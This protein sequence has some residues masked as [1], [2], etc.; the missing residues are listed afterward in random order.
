MVLKDYDEVIDMSSEEIRLEML[1]MWHEVDFNILT[2]EESDKVDAQLKLYRDV[3]R[4]RH[5]QYR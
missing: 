1:Q 5:Y 2:K 4:E 3:L